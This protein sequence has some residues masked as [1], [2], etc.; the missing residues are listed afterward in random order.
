MKPSSD[1]IWD[2]DKFHDECG[3]FGVYAPGE[4]VA[5]L[6]FFGLYALQH[7]G[8]E[9]AGIAVSDGE[10]ILVYKDMG[11]VPQVFSERTIASLT[12]RAAIG[13]VRYSTTGSTRWENAQPVH[14]DCG[15]RSIVLAHNGN[16]VNTQEIREELKAKGVPFSSTSDSEV[17]ASLI[18]VNAGEGIERS[19]VAAMNK[20]RGAYSAVVQTEDALY[21]MQDPNGIR[22]LS[23]GK[24]ADGW[25]VASETCGLDIVGAE[26]VRDVEPGE[27]LVIDE[28][29]A[30]S[31]REVEQSR[32]A[33]CIFE[34]VYFA[35]PD[36]KMNGQ[37]IYKARRAMGR[38]LASES[39]ADVDLV[40]GVP[41]SGTPAAIGFAEEAGVPFGEG[42]IKNRYVGRTFIQPSQT[43]RQIG[44]RMKLNPLSE[45]IGG[46]RLALV[47]DSI[48]RGTTSRKI[49]EML[50]DAGAL[51]VH[52]RISSP[53]VAWPCFYGIDTANRDELIGSSKAVKEI[54][55]HIGVDSLSYLSLEGLV[56]ATGDRKDRFCTACFDGEYPV[57]VPDDVKLAKLMMEEEIRR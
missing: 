30:R 28:K 14:K 10:S 37:L 38:M 34:Y 9:S 24:L 47:D 11:L 55:E 4:D 7:R 52:M 45:V 8:Q 40:I 56:K 50:R 26:F 25:V 2:D 15:G 20:L 5:R 44:V 39:P 19:I 35:R 46:K 42:L 13:H 31:V 29:G 18:A 12:G 57:A 16:L 17:M 27:L 43:I 53:P 36:S 33:R 32:P 49:V 23:L 22:P 6:T 3:V 54:A 51:E 21:A 48:V 1:S 41:D